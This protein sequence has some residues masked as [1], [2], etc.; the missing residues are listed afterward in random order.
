MR[1]HDGEDRARA[2]G[3]RRTAVESEPADPEEPGPDHRQRQIV[4][5]EILAAVT[6]RP[7]DQVSGDEPGDAR[8]EVDDGAACKIQNAELH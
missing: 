2:C 7:A 6:R 4:R 5:C 3:Q 1:C 8:I